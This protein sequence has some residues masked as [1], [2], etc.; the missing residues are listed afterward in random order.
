MTPN[1]FC[2]WLQGF[3]EV[4]NPE[5][6]NEEQLKIVKQHLELVFKNVTGQKEVLTDGRPKFSR[7]VLRDVKLC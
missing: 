3:L 5:N 1:D 7:D 2:Y 6:M 4:A